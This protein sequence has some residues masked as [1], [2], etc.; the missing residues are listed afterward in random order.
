MGCLEDWAGKELASTLVSRVSIPRRL[1]IPRFPADHPGTLPAKEKHTRERAEFLEGHDILNSYVRILGKYAQEDV[2][3][4]QPNSD[5][6]LLRHFIDLIEA[7]RSCNS[8]QDKRIKEVEQQYAQL[9]DRLS[10]MESIVSI[11]RHDRARQAELEYME[12]PYSLDGS[13]RCNC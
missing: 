13:P 2:A 3:V 6:D 8:F 11:L 4:Q 10:S 9:E 7:E 5:L 12:N 1:C